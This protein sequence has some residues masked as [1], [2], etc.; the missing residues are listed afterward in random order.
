MPNIVLVFGTRYHAVTIFNI[1]GIH[2]PSESTRK[3]LT[4]ARVKVAVK[5]KIENVSVSIYL[6]QWI[7]TAFNTANLKKI[8]IKSLSIALQ[9][10][11]DKINIANFRQ[12][13]GL[14]V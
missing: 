11:E 9:I 12:N 13:E 6:E 10:W 3:R 5:L 14:W 4:V 8:T 1:R 7:T 2:V